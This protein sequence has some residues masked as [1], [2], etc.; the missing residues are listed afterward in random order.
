MEG[1]AVA[2]LESRDYNDGKGTLQ[3]LL[4]DPAQARRL[5]HLVNRDGG[6]RTATTSRSGT[7]RRTSR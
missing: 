5:R 4:K 1:Q 3:A 7:N 6:F 2:D